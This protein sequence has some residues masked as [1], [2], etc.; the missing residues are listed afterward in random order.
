MFKKKT[1]IAI[2]GGGG[3]GLTTAAAL[4]DSNC[5]LTIYS[6][7]KFSLS[8]DGFTIKENGVERLISVPIQ[9]KIEK[10]DDL[11]YAFIICPADARKH[12]VEQ[13]L[14]KCSEKTKIVLIP[15]GLGFGLSDNS[16]RERGWY[17]LNQL[18]YVTRKTGDNTAELYYRLSKLW[19]A[20][21]PSKKTDEAVDTIEDL[22]GFRPEKCEH[23]LHCGLLNWNMLLHPPLMLTNA[24]RIEHREEFTFYRTGVNELAVKIMES[25]DTERLKT[26]KKM[27][28]EFPTLSTYLSGQETVSLKDAL[29]AD[30]ATP[31][32]LAP[33]TITHRYLT[34]DVPYNLV[35]LSQLGKFLGQ[36][37]STVDSIIEIYRCLLRT[38]NET[39]LN[40]ME[41]ITPEKISDYAKGVL[42]RKGG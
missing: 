38:E 11:D 29:L 41:E 22:L 8:G 10:L 39:R 16:L 15:G 18:P 13:V 19:C 12:Y 34:E 5:D 37:M 25:M 24:G 7:Y 4:S 32:I 20:A 27:G 14:A 40:F 6:A 21:Y 33:F 31:R 42:K 35:P 23:T 9:C 3:G 26:G 1:K 17:E 2:F 30:E 28:L 36:D